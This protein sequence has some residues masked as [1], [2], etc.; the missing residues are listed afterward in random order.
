MSDNFYTSQRARLLKE[1][2]QVVRR[3]REIFV[4]R[5]GEELTD[6]MIGGVRHEYETL[7]PE[8]PYVGGK[9]PF[10]RFI[11]SSGWFLA[12]YRVLRSQGGTVEEAGELVYESSKAFLR[13]YPG[14]LRRLFGHTIFSRRRLRR[15]RKHAAESQ[16]RQYPGDYVYTFVEGDGEEFDFGVDYT[17]CAVCKFLSEQGAP[18]LA[19]YICSADE[20]YSEALGWGLMRTMTLAD[21]H[22][23]CDFRFK[24]GGKTRVVLPESLKRKEPEDAKHRAA[25]TTQNHSL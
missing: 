13:A 23:K 17:E 11:I 9:Q 2:D 14:F 25:R 6:T 24:R 10:T 15:L 19:P 7:I 16:E 20:I 22:E 4:S 12:M 3:I 8:L 1:F 21:G 5:Y 18:E